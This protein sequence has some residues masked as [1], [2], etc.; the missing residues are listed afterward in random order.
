MVIYP[1]V[2]WRTYFNSFL[3][4]LPGPITTFYRPLTGVPD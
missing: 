1:R 3:E 2:N 4:A